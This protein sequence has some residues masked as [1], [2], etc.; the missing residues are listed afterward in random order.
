[1]DS[2]TASPRFKQ[3]FRCQSSKRRY[4]TVLSGR[5]LDRSWP[6][7]TL[8]LSI[9]NHTPE[10]VRARVLAVSILVF[11]GAMAA[12]SAVWGAL[13]TKTGIHAALMW[14]GV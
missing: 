5:L 10:W 3:H 1:M 7:V 2:G 13:A 6:G 11:Q 14:A 4:C 12:G 9:L 8:R